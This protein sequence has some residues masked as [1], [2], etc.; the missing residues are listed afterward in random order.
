MKFGLLTA[1]VVLSNAHLSCILRWNILSYF[2]YCTSKFFH[3]LSLALFH[4]S[5]STHP[6][7]LFI[8]FSLLLLLCDIELFS[9]YLCVWSFVFY[10]MWQK[11]VMQHIISL[12]MVFKM[13]EDVLAQNKLK[14]SCEC[15]YFFVRPFLS[16][17][18]L[19]HFKPLN[20]EN[21]YSSLEYIRFDRWK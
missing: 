4:L 14:F 10:S 11:M 16:D 12:T 15:V 1:L 20:T 8:Y 19:S 7:H 9:L 17:N 2:T 6:N 18:F 3:F 21:I 5:L 13:Y